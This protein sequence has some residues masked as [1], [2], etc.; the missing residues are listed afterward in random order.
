MEK[1]KKGLWA[2][3][4]FILFIGLVV[5]GIAD[6]ELLDSLRTIWQESNPEILL[7]YLSLGLGFLSLVLFLVWMVVRGIQGE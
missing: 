2:Q 4:I 1:N 5:S 7:E 3:I 6:Q